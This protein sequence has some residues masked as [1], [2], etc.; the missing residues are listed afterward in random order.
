MHVSNIYIT[1]LT[2][3]GQKTVGASNNPV[4]C[5]C[6]VDFA[7]RFVGGGVTGAGLVQEEIRFLINPELIASRLI[8]E[9][10]D[11][12]ECLIITGKALLLLSYSE[13]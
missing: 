4:N 1:L 3:G 13:A 12:N 8:T 5:F 6:Q 10:L 9:V 7:N 11:H 2:E